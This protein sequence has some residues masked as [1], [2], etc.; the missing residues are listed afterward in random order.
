MSVCRKQDEREM[1]KK[2]KY[3]N[4]LVS[5]IMAACNDRPEYICMAVESILNQTYRYFELLILDDSDEKATIEA[6]DSYRLDARVRIYRE[7]HRIGFVPSLNKGLGLA[8]GAFIARMDGDDVASPDRLE[9]Q[10]RYFSTRPAADILGGQLNIM[11]ETGQITGRRS[12]PLGGFRLAVFFCMRTPVAHPAVMFKR[13]VA[14]AGYR[15]DESL[16]RAEDID[17]WL[18]LFNAGYRIENL[19][20]TILNFRAESDFLTKRVTDKTQEKYV[21][22][23]RRKNFSFKRP[24]FSMAGWLFSY[25]RQAAPDR[26]KTR[27]YDRENRARMYQMQNRDFYQGE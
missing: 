26:L 22:A 16:K 21:L 6:I 24:L 1:I 20:D 25:I 27:V 14:D 5:V 7:D 9:K 17:F 18:R 15:Y 19:P 23:I 2:E 12:Y 3:K 8:K 11:D 4:P 10:V 13:A